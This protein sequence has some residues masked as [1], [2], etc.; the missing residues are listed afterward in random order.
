MLL[1]MKD[2][3]HGLK[4]KEFLSILAPFEKIQKFFTTMPKII[5]VLKVTNPKTKKKGEV[6]IEGIQSFFE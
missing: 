4:K 2:M 6:I 5:H 1:G 3:L